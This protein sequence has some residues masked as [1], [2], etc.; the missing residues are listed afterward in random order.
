MRAT[1]KLASLGGRIGSLAYLLDL[2]QQDLTELGE[3]PEAVDAV[4]PELET[5]ALLVRNMN[6]SLYSL[7]AERTKASDIIRGG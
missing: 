4:G 3:M 1:L 5:M 7:S 6:V 2:A